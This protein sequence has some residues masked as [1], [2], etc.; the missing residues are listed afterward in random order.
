MK[1]LIRQITDKAEGLQVKISA[2]S[3]QFNKAE[4]DIDKEKYILEILATFQEVFPVV[5]FIMQNTK[6]VEDIICSQKYACDLY[7]KITGKEYG[8]IE[9][10]IA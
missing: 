5:D 9:G 10:D 3:N 8:S 1:E 6:N 4:T 2:L 7:K